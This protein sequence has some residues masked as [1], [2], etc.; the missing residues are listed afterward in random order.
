MHD[1]FL[2]SLAAQS[3]ALKAAKWRLHREAEA[4]VD[5]YSAGFDFIGYPEGASEVL[6]VDL[7]CMWCQYNP[8]RTTLYS[9][10]TQ[11]SINQLSHPHAH[12]KGRVITEE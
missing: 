6:S 4:L 3:R 5:A 8:F 2:S 9:Y 12:M 7:G 11:S 10:T 1:S